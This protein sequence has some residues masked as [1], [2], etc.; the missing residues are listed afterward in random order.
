MEKKISNVLLLCATSTGHQHLLTAREIRP[1][2]GNGDGSTPSLLMIGSYKSSESAFFGSN[3]QR[4]IDRNR[5]HNRLHP[6]NH[7]A[8]S[9]P[10]KQTVACSTLGMPIKLFPQPI[11]RFKLT[12]KASAE[13]EIEKGERHGMRSRRG[14]QLP[15]VA[16]SG[17]CITRAEGVPL[18]GMQR[19]SRS[20][21]RGRRKRVQKEFM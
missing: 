19:R 1:T 8:T 12:R 4:A 11:K 16:I 9:S 13:G 21:E 20:R 2:E 14:T 6:L 5:I 3:R 10:S 18:P 7:H 15:G 17:T